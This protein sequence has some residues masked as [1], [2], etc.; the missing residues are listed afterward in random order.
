MKA[1]H[2]AII[3]IRASLAALGL[4]ILQDRYPL[5][6]RMATGLEFD[7]KTHALDRTFVL[8]RQCHHPKPMPRD[9]S[10]FIM[11]FPQQKR[12]TPLVSPAF[13]LNTQYPNVAR[14]L[15]SKAINYDTAAKTRV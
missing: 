1:R 7:P 15:E 14:L 9:A 8:P 2:A 12:P 6:G 10:I 11:F 4:W 5:I 3:D 13:A